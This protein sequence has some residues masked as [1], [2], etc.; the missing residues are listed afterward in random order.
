MKFK[1]SLLILLFSTTILSAQTTFGIKAGLNIANIDYNIP[2]SSPEGRLGGYVGT[3]VDFQLSE[4]FHLQPEVQYSTEG[5]EEGSVS[6]VNVPV[7]LKWFF[8]EGIHINA[9]PQL[10]I[11]IDAE[12]GTNG[13]NTTQL[14][15]VFGLGYE[16]SGGFMIDSR[17][18]MGVTSIIDKNFAVDSGLGYNIVGIQGWT[19]TLS[20]GIGYKF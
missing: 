8:V 7:T 12:G 4:K 19:R 18:A 15:G 2:D 16:T 10:G 1:F 3:L 5:I 11:V 20:F 14:A 13:L 9:G 6:F 17:F